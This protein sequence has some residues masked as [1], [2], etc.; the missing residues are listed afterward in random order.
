[1][2]IL[3]DLQQLKS[4]LIDTIMVAGFEA[5]VGALSKIIRAYL[6]PLG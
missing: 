2:P 1:M 5:Y 3:R 4:N 6:V